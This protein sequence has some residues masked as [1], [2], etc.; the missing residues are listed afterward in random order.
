MKKLKIC[1]IAVMLMFMSVSG[2]YA[3]SNISILD[4]EYTDNVYKFSESGD[5]NLPFIRVSNGRMEIDKDVNKSGF[6]FANESL[7]VVNNLK[8]IQV[9]TSSDTVRINGNI[10][11]GVVVA[12]TVIVEGTIDRSIMI[13]SENV[14]ISENAVIKE[15]LLC[16]SGKI[17]LLGK[18]EGSLLGSIG[19]ANISGNIV[20]DLR[21]NIS[22]IT[23]GEKSNIQGNIYLRSYNNID[24]SAKYPNAIVNI[25]EKVENTIDIWGIV[26]TSLI[27]AL[28]YL[29]ISNKTNFVKN[30]LNKVKVYSKSTALFG[31]AC[32]LLFP[33]IILVII[34]LTIFG[35]GIITI[36]ALIMYGTFMLVAFMLSTFITGSVMCEY[37]SNKY[38]NKIKGNWEKLILAFCLIFVLDLL[39]NLPMIGY[40]LSV[41]LCILSTGILFT[42]IFRRIKVEN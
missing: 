6:S 29:L 18:I 12:P 22:G 5:I 27:F 8:G 2:I 11:Y 3:V 17:D 13:V 20:R 1:I 36:P 25:I 14:T 42:S 21:A 35:L 40:T 19:Q 9:L 30:L 39:T 34:G 23:L 16:M 41:A 24:I 28:I 4:M 33:A 38:N 15:D 31:F 37:I 26:R 10:E 32:I 7:S